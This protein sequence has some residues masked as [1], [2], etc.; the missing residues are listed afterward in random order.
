MALAPSVMEML[1]QMAIMF[2]TEDFYSYCLH[3]AFHHPLLYRFHKEHHEYK[4]PIPIAAWHFHY[5]EYIMLQLVASQLYF[6]TAMMYAPLHISTTM[7]WFI[8][9]FWHNNSTHVGYNFPWW[10]TSLIPFTLNDEF[11]DFHHTH[12]S[13]NYGLYLRIWDAIFG[14][15]KD[16]RQW[17]AKKKA[18][19]SK[20]E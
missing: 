17:K 13:G 8:F 7:I 15:T 16:F 10:P 2:I 11:H 20:S 5:V 19:Q 9:R 14:D 3:K 6:T 4:Y 18:L 12:N 1:P